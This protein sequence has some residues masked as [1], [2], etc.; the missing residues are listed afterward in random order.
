M[1]IVGDADAAGLGDRFQPG[2]DIDAVAENV[3]VVKNDVTDVD[4]DPEF[5]PSI[6]RR[7]VI[8][9]VTPR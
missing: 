9:W 6:L 4:T 7:T 1:G 8:R 2:C 3:V 5:N